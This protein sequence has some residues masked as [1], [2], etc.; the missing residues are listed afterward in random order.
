MVRPPID[1]RMILVS[2]RTWLMV[3]LLAAM[4]LFCAP[5]ILWASG[6]RGDNVVL[7]QS[8]IKYPGGY[9]FN[10]VG[11][12]KGT[13]QKIVVPESGPV[14]IYVYA[15]RETYAV[16]ASPGGYWKDSSY[17]VREGIEIIV[18]G[19]KAMGADGNLYMIAQR[20]R[21]LNAD[22][23]IVLRDDEGKPA[24]VRPKTGISGGNAG[25]GS[26]LRGGGT[27]GSPSGMGRGRR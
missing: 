3:L 9:D 21:I 15:G 24:W 10:T 7:P 5:G 23:T 27:G 2:G 1:S 18:Q 22:K 16:L 11:E 12:I 4:I 13:V 8:G 26:P 25:F 20:I 14:Q 17:D 19:S 6:D